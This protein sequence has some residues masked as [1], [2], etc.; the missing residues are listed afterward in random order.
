MAKAKKKTGTGS[1]TPTE[2]AVNLDNLSARVGRSEQLV[3]SHEASIV[4][5][6]GQIA[7]LG[8]RLDSVGRAA[9]KFAQAGELN[10][11]GI[12]DLA[13]QLATIRTKVDGGPLAVSSALLD[14]FKVAAET[15][16]R[17]EL[18]GKLR[19]LT[20]DIVRDELAEHRRRNPLAR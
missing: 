13:S 6:A 4:D 9:E 20:R 11:K 3:D 8:A 17:N 14:E 5:Q 10:A 7:Q 1:H 2:N 18:G 19:E 15:Y 12:A 16:V